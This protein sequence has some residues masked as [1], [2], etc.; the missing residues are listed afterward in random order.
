MHGGRKFTPGWRFS[1]ILD[2]CSD[3]SSDLSS[4][5][6]FDNFLKILCDPHR[7]RKFAPESCFGR[8]FSKMA[9][10][11]LGIAATR[12]GRGTACVSRPRI[13]CARSRDSIRP[14]LMR[15]LKSWFSATP[16]F[17]RPKDNRYNNNDNNSGPILTDRGQN[18]TFRPSRL[19]IVT[20]VAGVK[21]N[22]FVEVNGMVINIVFVLF[23]K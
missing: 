4:R 20:R 18:L 9:Q 16:H 5:E 19:A 15:I 14:A 6:N 7:A 2:L 12:A 17:L 11:L 22:K 8:K 13:V 1:K 10:I 23:I 3:L 21:V